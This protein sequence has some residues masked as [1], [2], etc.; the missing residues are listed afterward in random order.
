MDLVGKSVWS[1]TYQI[2][3]LLKRYILW[4]YSQVCFFFKSEITMY[5]VF[6]EVRNIIKAE[7]MKQKAHRGPP[8]SLS[9]SVTI[10]GL[11]CLYS[12]PRA[13]WAPLKFQAFRSM[14]FL[15][16][17]PCSLWTGQLHWLSETQFFWSKIT[18]LRAKAAFLCLASD[19]IH[20]MEHLL[21]TSL[22]QIKR[23]HAT[24]LARPGINRKD[25]RG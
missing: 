21:D 17:P 4:V 7:K 19:F 5:P 3:L 1:Q 10:Q 9:P 22:C 13:V 2:H 6:A 15:A 14:W 25:F 18:Q 8:L 24:T 23:S 12:C 16:L 20:H 11:V